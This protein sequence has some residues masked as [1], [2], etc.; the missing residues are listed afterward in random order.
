[1]KAGHSLLFV[2]TSLLLVDLYLLLR[3]LAAHLSETTPI[4]NKA[5][6]N[7]P[8]TAPRFGGHQHLQLAGAEIWL[9]PLLL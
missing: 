6:M 5:P 8:L 4:V 1:M 7:N 2:N 3:E 9:A